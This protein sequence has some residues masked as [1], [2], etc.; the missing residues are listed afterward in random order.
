MIIE[1][2]NFPRKAPNFQNQQNSNLNNNQARHIPINQYVDIGNKKEMADKTFD[3]LQYKL[4]NGL[5]SLD[6][7]KKKCDKLRKFREK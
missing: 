4:K 1:K 5:I 7:F 3:L 2:D 6:E